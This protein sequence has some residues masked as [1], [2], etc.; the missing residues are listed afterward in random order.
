MNK[1]TISAL[2]SDNRIQSIDIL[3]GIF[4]ILMALDHVR[5]YFLAD[6]FSFSP[7]DHEKTHVA[8]FA[9]RFITHIC[10][11]GFAWLSGISAYMYFKKN[12]LQKSTSFLLSRGVILI[13]LEFTIVKFAWHFNFDYS[14][15]GLLVIWALGT[16]MVLLGL[17]SWLKQQTIFV[18]GLVVLIGHNIL[19][20]ITTS[21]SGLN[22]LLWHV[23]HQAGNVS[24]SENFSINVLYPLL[25]MYG[26]ICL[27]YGMGSL[28]TEDSKEE[29]IAL[30]KRVSLLLLLSFISIRLINI[31]GD[32]SPWVSNQYF[33]RTVFSFFNVT[34]YPMSLDYILIT[35][36]IIFYL[37]SKIESSTWKANQFLSLFGKV[38]M[39]FYI[40][41]I[42]FVHILAII[43]FVLINFQ[44]I[45]FKKLTFGVTE[46]TGQYGYSLWVVYIVWI[47]ILILL[48]PVCKKYRM[49]K[50]KH[51]QSFL[52]F[53]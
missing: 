45:E 31:Y 41:H 40:I 29:R 4:I 17:T 9:T 26:L 18:I 22:S 3:R 46:I 49:F 52:R 27:G 44:T 5:D 1:H 21:D 8:L 43:L 28:F 35:L 10:A 33:Y 47:G 42:F 24:L 14:T 34:K 53:I 32:P 12:G 11:T 48:Y 50:S 15:V 38:S 6:A 13:I 36:S 7:T 25:P 19:D 37:L 39:F 16:S 30:F 23:L 20:G 51:P 2:S